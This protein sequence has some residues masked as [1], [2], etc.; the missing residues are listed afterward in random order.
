MSRWP[1][2]PE[3]CPK[4]GTIDYLVVVT[5]ENGW[6]HVECE[7]GFNGHNGE[8]GCYYLGPGEGSQKQAIRSHNEQV[9]ALR[10]KSADTGGG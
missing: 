6:R 2:K 1:L 3:P 10:A 8:K 9:R 5:Y 7:R 4:C